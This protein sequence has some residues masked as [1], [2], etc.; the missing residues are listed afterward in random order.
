VAP[1]PE[2]SSPQSQQPP[3]GPYPEPDEST[4]H[5]SSQYPWGPF[6]SHPPICVLV[7]SG[8]FP[9]GFHT[10]TLYT[11]LP[12][13][14]SATCPAHLIQRGSVIRFVTNTRFY[15]GALLAPPPNP[16][17]G[18]PPPVG[19]PR[20]LIHYIRSYPPS[21]KAV[22]S[23]RNLRTRLALVTGDVTTSGGYYFLNTCCLVCIVYLD[24]W[25]TCATVS[26]VMQIWILLFTTSF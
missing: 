21:L 4:P 20:L 22:F 23:I 12:S 25:C 17:T 19:C 6:W 10:R 24:Y 1:E 18:G 9:W 26:A 7:L 3:N 11:F 5:P 13:P 2:G 16:R 14:M 15:G 8:L